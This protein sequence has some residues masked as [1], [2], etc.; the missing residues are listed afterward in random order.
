M[1]IRDVTCTIL[2]TGG[3]GYP[4]V[5]VWGEDGLVGIG[6]ASPMHPQVTK[7]AVEEQ[8]KPL[9]VGMNALDLEACWEKMYISTYKVRGQGT[10]IAIS[11]VDIA[12]H[13]LVGKILG[14]PVYQLLGGKYRG[15]V[16]VYAS[17][18]NRDLAPEAYAERCVAAVEAGFTAVKIKTGRVFGFDGGDLAQD[19]VLV[20]T[21]RRAVG[22]QV[23]LLVDANSG[24]S[25]PTAI[26]FGRVLEEYRAHHF[27]EPVPYT[28]LEGTAQVAAALDIPVAG[29]EQ[30]HTRYD[31]RE[32]LGRNAV[33]IVQPDV[34]KCGGLS[35]IK[36]IAALAD[37]FGRYVTTHCTSVSIGLAAALHVWASTPACRY[38]QEFNWAASQTRAPFLATPLVPE[39]GQFTVPDAPGLGVA[40]DEEA[41]KRLAADF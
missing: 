22:D 1:R 8:L 27:E 23:E 11:G 18:M 34:T 30:H 38:A 7:V 33:D 28:D 29:G 2:R 15:H 6:E 13:D 16:R 25:V 26:R 31:F 19:E 3:R 5:R 4:L 20:R 41:V 14:V 9:L 10:S 21:V 37:A 35:E 32:L 40:L 17:F 39:N 36:K 24:Y 12:L